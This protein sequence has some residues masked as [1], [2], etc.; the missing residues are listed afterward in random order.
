MTTAFGLGKVVSIGRWFLQYS[1]VVI[2]TWTSGLNREVIVL[3][4][5]LIRQAI[6]YILSLQEVVHDEL[7]EIYLSMTE[8]AKAQV[9]D[10]DLPYYEC[11]PHAGQKALATHQADI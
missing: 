10:T 4:G 8:Q 5:S 6:L 9:V 7:M 3:Q 2:G 11:G 1:V